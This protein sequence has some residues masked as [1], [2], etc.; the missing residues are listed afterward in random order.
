MLRVDTNNE[1][2]LTRGDTA[3]I[4]PILKVE[5]EEKCNKYNPYEFQEGDTIIFRLANNN[6]DILIEKNCVIDLENNKATLTLLPS[7][8][9][10]LDPKVYFYCFELVTATDDHFTFVENARFT[11]GK[12][13]EKRE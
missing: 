10:N 12:E 1:I 7:D 5:D 11:L 6:S 13:L 4:K 9:E 2:Y 8:T 3:Y